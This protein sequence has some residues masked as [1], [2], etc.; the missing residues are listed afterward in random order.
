MKK[1]KLSI[2]LTLI[3]AL[4]LVGAL[5]TPTQAAT[6]SWQ[7]AYAEVLKDPE[8]FYKA[9]GSEDEYAYN[10]YKP[11]FYFSLKD[12][13]N[14]GVPELIV[15]WDMGGDG[16]TCE[17]YTYS[18]GIKELGIVALQDEFSISSNSKYP[19]LFYCSY[20][21]NGTEAYNYV[22]IK[23]NKLTDEMFFQMEREVITKNNSTL[24][25]EMNKAKSLPTYSISDKNIANVIYSYGKAPDA[26]PHPYATALSTYIE[27]VNGDTVAF[28]EDINGDGVK[29]MLADKFA[30]LY[31]ERLYY[32]YNGNLCTYN[33]DIDL[34]TGMFF[35]TNKNLILNPIGSGY[36]ILTIKKG[37]VTEETSL[38]SELGRYDTI[39]YQDHKEISKSAYDKLLKKYGITPDDINK[40]FVVDSNGRVVYNR[41]NQTIQVLSMTTD[42]K[43]TGIKLN[44][45]S[46]TLAKGKTYALKATIVPAK[47]TTKAVKWTSS[48]TKV[49]TVDKKGKVKAIGKGKATIKATAT[50]GSKVKKT[51]AVIVK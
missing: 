49:A 33:I 20:A 10:K 13:D 9:Y 18:K 1:K 40:L 31:C 26:T 14:N 36:D 48:N 3:M 34:Y 42:I 50:D 11:Y 38:R 45:T 19:G 4:G 39:Y 43:V 2:I 16:H 17:I 5:T 32:I 6:I 28:L 22:K 41:K 30:S 12:I 8:G 15:R 46:I 24:L 51:C 7:D 37:K 44:K 23:K 25:A 35:S 29:E 47:A 21:Y 27:D